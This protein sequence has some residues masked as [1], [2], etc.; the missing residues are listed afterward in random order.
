MTSP[1]NLAPGIIPFCFHSYCPQRHHKRAQP[2][3][4]I[5]SQAAVKE[6]E[7]RNKTKGEK[8]ETNEE[9]RHWIF[10]KLNNQYW[11]IS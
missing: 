10:L 6:G 2:K 8:D 3:Y 5:Q 11:H 7:E 9:D 4:Q 1:E